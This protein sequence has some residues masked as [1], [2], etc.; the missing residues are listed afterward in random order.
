M[1]TQRNWR[2]GIGATTAILLG[3]SVVACSGDAEPSEDTSDASGKITVWSWSTN[4][5]ELADL[6]MEEHPDIEVELIN[7]GDGTTT[8]ERLATAFQAGTGAPDVAMIEHARVLENAAQGYIVPLTDYGIE[9]IADDLAPRLLSPLTY[10]AEIYGSRC[11]GP[12]MGLCYRAALFEQ[13]GIE[14]PATWDGFATAAERLKS[15][16]PDSYIA[17]T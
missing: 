6:F 11:G 10:S 5:A 14:P 2:R 13:A 7:P 8:T 15:A 1:S 9:K 12:P 4:A 16:L 17:N 3:F